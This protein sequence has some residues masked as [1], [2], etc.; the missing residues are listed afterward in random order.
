[1]PAVQVSPSWLLLLGFLRCRCLHLLALGPRSLGDLH[2]AM[3]AAQQ[4]QQ[5]SGVALDTAL[6]KQTLA[7]ASAV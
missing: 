5:L 3:R 7:Q 2:K 6:L 1:M 4:Q